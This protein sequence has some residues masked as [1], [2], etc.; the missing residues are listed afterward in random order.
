MYFDDDYVK[1]SIYYK[2]NEVI[3]NK[4]IVTGSEF[5]NNE[6]LVDVKNNQVNIQIGVSKQSE[7]AAGI[8]RLD[9]SDVNNEA[10]AETYFS[11]RKAG[12]NI[13]ITNFAMTSEL[14]YSNEIASGAFNI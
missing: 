11:I 12:T 10:F 7:V 9:V 2:N 1:I 14:I 13:Q 3:T 4:F 6:I 5:T 8:Y